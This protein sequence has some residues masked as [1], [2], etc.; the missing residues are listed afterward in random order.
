MDCAARSDGRHPVAAQPALSRRRR[1]LTWT[2]WLPIEDHSSHQG[3]AVYQIRAVRS[4]SPLTISRVLGPDHSGVV[5]IGETGAFEKRRKQFCRGLSSGAG[6]SEANLIWVL[7]RTTKVKSLLAGARLEY[8]FQV[9]DSK[10]SAVA[11]EKSELWAYATRFGEVPPF[12]SSFPGRSE[13][14]ARYRRAA[15]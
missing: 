5:A 6:H 14:I 7:S 4:R 13:Q 3:P 1:H 9:R 8:R 11:L 12:N 15:R 2:K 10:K